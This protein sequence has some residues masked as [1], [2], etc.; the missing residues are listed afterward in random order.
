LLVGSTATSEMRPDVSA[1]PMERKRMLPTSDAI[2]V[3]SGA[4]DEADAGAVPCLTVD[5]ANAWVEPNA[6]H[7]RNG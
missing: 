7:T 2:F 4:E 1:G 5:W 6:T 3:V